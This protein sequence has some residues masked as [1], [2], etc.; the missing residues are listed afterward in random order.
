[1]I[2]V[3]EYSLLSRKIK[4]LLIVFQP[5]LVHFVN[6]ALLGVAGFYYSKRLRLPLITS[7]H[8]NIPQYADYYLFP[9]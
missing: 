2:Y 9:L 3:I 1:M 7:Y 4:Y 8:I 5:D 6:P